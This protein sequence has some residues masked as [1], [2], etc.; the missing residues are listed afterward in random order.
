MLETNENET[1]ILGG[2][3][4]NDDEILESL[5]EAIMKENEDVMEILRDIYTNEDFEFFKNYKLR[6]MIGNE[7]APSW[8][9]YA[10]CRK[11]EEY[12]EFI[13]ELFNKEDFFKETLFKEFSMDYDVQYYNNIE[14]VKWYIREFGRNWKKMAM[15][16]DFE[17]WVEDI[18]YAELG[19][20]FSEKLDQAD[21]WNYYE[22]NILPYTL[23]RFYEWLGNTY[24]EDILE[25]A[26]KRNLLSH[27]ENA[28][29]K[30]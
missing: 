20:I 12:E 15:K 3:F 16:D 25:I 19:D 23:D 13:N 18:S 1:K 28:L 14:D 22:N 10:D 7:W 2:N 24:N 21:I 29:K 27:L 4:M 17:N 26:K 30:I 11:K 5:E 6:A 9:W 8:G